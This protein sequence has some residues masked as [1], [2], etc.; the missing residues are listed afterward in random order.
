MK[1]SDFSFEGD[2]GTV[3]VALERPEVM[4][5]NAERAGEVE[6]V[7]LA[8]N[9]GDSSCAAGCMVDG[10]G[11]VLLAMVYNEGFN[12]KAACLMSCWA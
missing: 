12:G 6:V 11:P 5:S 2:E 8:D 4:G 3:V 10:L 9:A 7:L 1:G